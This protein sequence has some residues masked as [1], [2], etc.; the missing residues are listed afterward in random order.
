MD[1]DDDVMPPPAAKAKAM[2][3]LPQMQSPPVGLRRTREEMDEISAKAGFGQ[4][5]DEMHRTVEEMQ[6]KM[7]EMQR[8]FQQQGSQPNVFGGFQ[9]ADVPR[10][11]KK[12]EFKKVILDKK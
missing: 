10:S 1:D 3:G 5:P 12:E 4:P 2:M 11:D 9:N 8:M 7:D 6:R